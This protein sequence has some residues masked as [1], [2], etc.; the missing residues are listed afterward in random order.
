MESRKMCQTCVLE[1]WGKQDMIIWELNWESSTGY[2]NSKFWKSQVPNKIKVI[3]WRALQ[4]ILPSKTRLLSKGRI[5][6]FTYEMCLEDPETNSHALWSCLY[7]KQ[8]CG[9]VDEVK[10]LPQP[11]VF[12]WLDLLEWILSNW[13]TLSLESFFILS[14]L[15]WSQRNNKWLGETVLEPSNLVH[16]G[17]E[18]QQ[19]FVQA[20]F[21]LD[22]LHSA[23]PMSW[24][25]PPFPFFQD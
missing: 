23:A 20:R 2:K 18:M 17:R 8:I 6:S 22:P 12:S 15:I 7:A 19:N 24:N 14:W 13:A 5:P 3:A 4:N 10:T 25:P 1:H 16:Q 11:A 9:L 21:N